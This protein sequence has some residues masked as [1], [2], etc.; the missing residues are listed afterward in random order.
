MRRRKVSMGKSFQDNYGFGSDA[1]LVDM[2]DFAS[3]IIF[4]D[5]NF[6]VVDK[7]GW[8][9]C[10]PSKN[11]PRSSLVG[12]AREYLGA[13][14]LHLVSRLDRETSGVVVLA[15]NHSAASAAQRAVDLGGCAK[16]KYLAILRGRL[17]GQVTVSQPLSDDKNSLVAIKTCCAVQKPSARPAVTVFSPVSHSG[18]GDFEE[19]TLAEVELLT[20][21]KHQ[22][23]AHAQWIGHQVVADKIYGPDE[24]LYLDFIEKGFT[25]DMAKLLPIRRQALH[26]YELDLSGISGGGV[27]RAPFPED[28]MEFARSRGL[29]VPGR[30]RG[31][32]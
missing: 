5:E 11:G 26:A 4:E 19:C 16:K 25:D 18:N 10:H 20:G 1:P 2:A 30:F 12:A 6:L 23:R 14:V 7:P 32:C 3:W 28:L 8:L 15:K 22:I 17:P 13:E 21:R 9:V 24:T 31:A 27:Y 29:D